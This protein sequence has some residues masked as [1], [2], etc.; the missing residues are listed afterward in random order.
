MMEPIKR[1]KYYNWPKSLCWECARACPK[2]CSWARDFIPVD[3]WTAELKRTGNG[4]ESYLVRECPEYIEEIQRAG[5]YEPDTD[6]CL[7]LIAELFRQIRHDYVKGCSATVTEID[8]FLRSKNGHRLPMVADAE[9]VIS[10]LRKQRKMY[11][12]GKLALMKR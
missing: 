6:G 7:N 11:Q 2:T 5:K 4:I 10:E 3:G 9:A 1:E 8:R 12:Q